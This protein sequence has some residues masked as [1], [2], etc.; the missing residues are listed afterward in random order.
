MKVVVSQILLG[1][2]L[3]ILQSH[4]NLIS[5]SGQDVPGLVPQSLLYERQQDLVGLPGLLGLGSVEDP[6]H[7]GHGVAEQRGAAPHLHALLALVSL[8]SLLPLLLGLGRLAAEVA[9]PHLGAQHAV[10]EG[11][12]LAGRLIFVS[13]LNET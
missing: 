3:V 1:G 5:S 10:V 9:V 13:P 12:H 2:H 7:L 8:G 6:G 4:E 11:E